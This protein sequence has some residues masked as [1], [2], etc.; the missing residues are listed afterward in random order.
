MFLPLPTKYIS[1]RED[2]TEPAKASEAWAW[3][4]EQRILLKK[5]PTQRE[6]AKHLCW[7][8]YKVRELVADF[9]TFCEQYFAKKCTKNRPLG[10]EFMGNIEQSTAKTPPKNHQSSNKTPPK[11][12]HLTLESPEPSASQKASKRKEKENKLLLLLSVKP[13]ANLDLS[14]VNEDMVDVFNHWAG[15]RKSVRAFRVDQARILKAALKNHTKHDLKMVIDYCFTAPDN[16]PYVKNWRENGWTDITNLLNRDK[17]SRNIEVSLD[18]KEG[19]KQTF[20]QPTTQNKTTPRF[21]LYI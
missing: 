14:S 16:L 17:V 5:K 21:N 6:I 15:Y 4:W 2:Y 18:W 12:D 7:S 3:L 20:K 10:D 9:Q 1:E 19:T 8:R 13:S 11:T